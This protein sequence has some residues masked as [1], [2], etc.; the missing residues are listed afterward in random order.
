MMNIAATATP[1]DASVLSR[2][3]WK[4]LGEGVAAELRH[5]QLYAPTVSTFRWWARRPH[6]VMGAILGAAIGKYGPGTAVADPFSGGGTVTFEAVRR[7][8]KAYAQDIHAWP[9]KGLGIALNG[10]DPAE[11]RRAAA[12]LLKELNPLRR[13]YMTEHGTELC[14]VVRVRGADCA[15]CGKRSFLFPSPML[16]LH[17]RSVGDRYAY[18]GCT[19]CGNAS[20]RRRDVKSFTCDHCKKRTT[21]DRA[22]RVCAHCGSANLMRGGYWHPVLVQELFAQGKGLRRRLRPVQPGDPVEARPAGPAHPALAQPIQAGVE[23]QRL[24]DAGFKCWGDLYT[25]RQM[26]VLLRALQ[27]VKQLRAHRAVK[28]RLALAVLGAAE[29]PA[30]LSRWDISLL[31]PF[32]AMANHRYAH[33]NLVAEANLL[34]PRGRGTLQ[35]RLKAAAAALDWLVE[36]APRYPRVLAQASRRRVRKSTDWDVM[37][38]TGSSR[39]QA[40]PSRSVNIVITDPPYYDD[41]QYGELARLFHAWLKIYWPRTVI[42][43]ADEAVPNKRKGVTPKDYEDTIAA[44]LVETKRT[45]RRGGRL[46][47][48]FHNKKLIAWRALAGALRAAGFAVDALAVVLAENDLDHC[49]RSVDA[50]LHDLVIECVPA[51]EKGGAGVHMAFAPRTPAE[52]NLAAVGLAMADFVRSAAAPDLALLFDQHLAGLKEGQHLIR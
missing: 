10:C 40:L 46:V 14:H 45:L 8:I 36:A 11:L 37:V 9:A 1:A 35:K 50:M 15:D 29:M 31:K 24:L 48:T 49:K 6:S 52:R 23:T 27:L 39:S 22:V 25:E 20:R 34:A 44:C 16:S 19:A 26:Q 42:D 41:V 51:A 12:Q 7:G 28:D 21:T 43:E 17:S 32:E 2:V 33:S 13:P 47:L 38:A 30:F 5:R 18:F 4:K 3:K